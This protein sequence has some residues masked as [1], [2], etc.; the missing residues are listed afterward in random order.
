MI[1]LERR[2]NVMPP[3]PVVPPR[4]ALALAGVGSQLPWELDLRRSLR[5][6]QTSS[7]PRFQAGRPGDHD[8]GEHYCT[9][10]GPALRVTPFIVER[11]VGM[12]L[13]NFSLLKR[14]ILF[15]LGLGF[16]V[17]IAECS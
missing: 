17:F 3:L 11:R 15:F 10:P 4:E 2:V 16:V 14:S 6:R 5:L 13:G 12:D 7:P 9:L 8:G 1:D